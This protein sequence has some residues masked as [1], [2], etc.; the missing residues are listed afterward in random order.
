MRSSLKVRKATEVRLRVGLLPLLREEA[1]QQLRGPLVLGLDLLL[2]D[3][4]AAGA[5]V[6][7]VGL[8]PVERPLGRGRGARV[9]ALQ[10][11]LEVAERRLGAVSERDRLLDLEGDGDP[12]VV[13]A[14]PVLDRDEVEEAD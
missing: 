11:G 10:L 9:A 2:F 3:H 12:A 4:P 14:V 13:G 5:G 1:V 7:D 8:E 6:L